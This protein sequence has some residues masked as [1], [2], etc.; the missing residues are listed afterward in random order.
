[1]AGSVEITVGGMISSAP[2]VGLKPTNS[3]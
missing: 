2:A 1:L 3:R